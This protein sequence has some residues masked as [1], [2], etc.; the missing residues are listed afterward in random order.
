MVG[1]LLLW[2]VR[3][4]FVSCLRDITLCSLVNNSPTVS[5]VERLASKR[6]LVTAQLLWVLAFWLKVKWISLLMQFHVSG[7]ENLM[8]D[9]SSRSW[10]SKPRWYCCT[11]ADLRLLFNTTFPLPKQMSWSVYS[12]SFDVSMHVISMLRMMDHLLD[13]W[14]LLPEIGRYIGNIGL[15]TVQL[16]E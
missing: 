12:P 14:W 3:R 5:W 2:W 6:S 10:G 11:D 4:R 7:C 13:E 9:I 8:T 15:P 16:W 1:L